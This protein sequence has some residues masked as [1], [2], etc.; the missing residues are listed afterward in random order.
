MATEFLNRLDAMLVD[1]DSPGSGGQDLRT[2]AGTGHT[3]ALTLFGFEP[4]EVL[5]SIAANWAVLRASSDQANV[6]RVQGWMYRPDDQ[7]PWVPHGNR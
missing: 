6:G 5:T 1:S 3:G 7:S 2:Q 4:S